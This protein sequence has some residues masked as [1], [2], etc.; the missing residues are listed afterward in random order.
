MEQFRKFDLEKQ[1]AISSL[2]NLRSVVVDMTD[3]GIDVSADL[4]KIDDAVASVQGDVLRI[5]LLG[6]FSD[7]KTSVIA[8]W[9]GK[10]M[11]DMKIDSDESSDRL[12]IYT[13]DGLPGKCKIIDTPG[14]F[15][16]KKKEVGAAPVMFED[17]TKRYISEAHL[18]FYVVDATNPLKDSHNDIVR[19]ILRDLNKLSSTIFVI[20]KMDEVADLTDEVLFSEQAR[21]KKDN[22]KGKLQRAA[23]LSTVEL[24]TLNIVCIA[25]DPNGRGLDFWF[26][27]PEAYEG[28]SRIGDL[29]KLALDVMSQSVPQALIAKTG[30]DV[31]RSLVAEK[32]ESAA[33]QFR[34]LD[35][36]EAKT[37]EDVR[38]IRQDI[39]VGR[40]EVKALRDQLFKELFEMEKQLLGR[41]RPLSIEDIKPFLEDE[42]G[43]IEG[44]VGFKLQMRVKAAID[45][46]FDQTSA[47]ASRISID[48]EGQLA[49]TESFVESMSHGALKSAGGLAKGLSKVP[50]DVIK[51]T[52][53]AARDGLAA[54]T[55]LAIK[56]KPWEATKMAA[57]F[58]K[59]AGPAGAAISIAADLIAAYNARKQEEELQ[60]IKEQIG[61]MIKATF[62]DIYDILRDDE[63]LFEF[64][65]PQVKEFGRILDDLANGAKLIHA[66][67]EKL[68]SIQ[69]RLEKVGGEVRA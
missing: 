17:I 21:I 68:R 63:K 23:S 16:D 49:S 8:G 66:N 11:D 14:L 3:I 7:G 60:K 42:I 56:F 59:W 36:Y 15:G 48:I 32:I 37:Q 52:I 62:K 57:A 5:A 64:F 13:P 6:A 38:R 54:L 28:R 26:T 41:L 1:A 46:L 58:S 53:F 25:S 40:K 2:T 9:L 67:R 22:L 47:I 50:V 19:W 45:R 69:S 4:A 61:G 35:V 12:E 55:G 65:A 51:T 10:I 31:V 43:Y 27:R 34:E 20:N 24:A 18:I 33:S 44:E 29:K 39:E 30:M